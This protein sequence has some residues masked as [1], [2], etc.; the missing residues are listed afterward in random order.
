MADFSATKRRFMRVF[1][2]IGAIVS[3]FLALMGPGDVVLTLSLFLVAQMGFVGANVFYDGFLPDIST[4][5][6]IDRVSSR[7]FA[8]GYI[9]GG[10]QLLAA[11]VIIVLHDSFG[12][13]EEDAARVGVAMAGVWWLLFGWWSM[14][15][16][17]ETGTPQAL[18][19]DLRGRSTI[20]AYTRIG[21]RRTTRTVRKLFGFPQLLLFVLAYM[22]YND[23]VQTTINLTAVYASDTLDLDT[24]TILIAFLIVQFIAFFGALGFGVLADRIGTKQAIQASLVVWSLV[25]VGAFALPEGAAM[26]FY[27]LAVVVGFILG[28][29][30]ALSRSL[31]GSMIPEEA[32]A[33]FYG[34]FS[35]FSKFSA[36][37]GPLI[38]AVVSAATGSGRPAILSIIA[39]FIIGMIL[40]AR[41]D[42]DAAR[43][44]R[45]RWSFAGDEVAT[46]DEP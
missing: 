8:L 24:E 3:I 25:A 23:G 28:G 22:F 26:P 1:A 32:S 13:T 29:V 17:P 40:L 43:A 9:G 20:S 45:E 42:I 5:D 27:G 6:T 36:I 21:L 44:S 10:V 12:L 34:F 38:F 7:G 14:T 39:F 31:Y 2:T 18:P 33:E 35:V 46:S 37:W 30:Q 15:R 4:D 11:A 41:V 19:A 16:F